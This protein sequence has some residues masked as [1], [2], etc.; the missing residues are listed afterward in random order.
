MG[1]SVKRIIND[2]RINS[3]AMV[4]ER[5]NIVLKRKFVSEKTDIKQKKVKLGCLKNLLE[6]ENKTRI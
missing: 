3:T 1:V 4:D 2:M 5:N 6:I